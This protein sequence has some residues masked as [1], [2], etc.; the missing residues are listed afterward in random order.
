MPCTKILGGII[1]TTNNFGRIHVG[2]KY[3]YFDYHSY[4][5]PSFYSDTGYTKEFI[6]EKDSEIWDKFESW[7]KKKG[8]RK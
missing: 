8:I 4:F 6:P 5:G 7:M 1:C 3:V 2:N